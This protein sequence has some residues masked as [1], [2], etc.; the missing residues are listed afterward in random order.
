[1]AD[2]VRVVVLDDYQQVAL[3]CGPW[4]RL[5]GRCAV[6]ALSEHVAGTDD[7][8]T[9]LRGATLGVVGLGRLG[10]AMVPIARAFGMDVI[11]WSQNLDAARAAEAGTAAVGKEEL[12][13][14]ADVVSVHYKLSERSAGIVGAAE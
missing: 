6:E 11:A 13:A 2:P 3:G 7:L 9:E 12:F 1:M 14:R 4:E 10:S 5:A 8:G